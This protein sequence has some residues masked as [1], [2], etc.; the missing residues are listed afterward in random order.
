M[1]TKNHILLH[2]GV[3]VRGILRQN[4]DDERRRR[5]LVLHEAGLADIQE[6][7]PRISVSA[8]RV[9]PAYIPAYVLNVRL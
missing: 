9:P 1:N 3:H 5:L 8:N 4:N 7:L 6:S 2:S